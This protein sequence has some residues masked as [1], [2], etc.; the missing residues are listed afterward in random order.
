MDGWNAVNR[1]YKLAL[2]C[3]PII[4]NDFDMKVLI[5]GRLNCGLEKLYGDKIEIMDFMPYFDFQE[6]L[7]ESRFLFIPNIFDA[8]PRVVSE[9]LIKDIP[10]LMNRQ[11]VC[12]SKYITYE[13][14]ELFTDENDITFALKKLVAK[15]KSISPK[16]WWKKNYSKKKMGKKLRDFLYEQYPSILKDINEVYFYM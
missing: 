13:T 6:K 1:N 10:V 2:E 3:L 4:I 16:N 11:V 5:I 12:G 7:R 15:E 8:S 14:G 9:A